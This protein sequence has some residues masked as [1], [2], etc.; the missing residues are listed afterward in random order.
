[1]SLMDL[2]QW[3]PVEAPV[4]RCDEKSIG[5]NVWYGTGISLR[6]KRID[7][8]HDSIIG[9]NVSILC[10]DGFEI[11]PCSYIGPRTTI[12]CWRFRAGSYLYC[13]DE[14]RVGHGSE[15]AGED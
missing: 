7:I 12:H 3:K 15:F 11:G 2:R 8:G 4:I 10:P 13:E 9:D 14:V 5:D 6:G 1:M